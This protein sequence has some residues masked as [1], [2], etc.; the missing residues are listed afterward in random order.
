MMAVRERENLKPFVQR[1]G[2]VVRCANWHQKEIMHLFFSCNICGTARHACCSV[3][4]LFPLTWNESSCLK[5]SG[6]SET[7]ASLKN[8]TSTDGKKK[9]NSY[10]ILKTDATMKI[11]CLWHF[12]PLMGSNTTSNVNIG[13]AAYCNVC[14]ESLKTSVMCVLFLRLVSSLFQ[15]RLLFHLAGRSFQSFPAV[16]PRFGSD[17]SEHRQEYVCVSVVLSMCVTS[18]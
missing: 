9:T 1:K 11:P 13:G 2:P 6:P 12:S 18:F 10:S 16:P 15:Q 8:F 3:E 5:V 7:I 14:C 17:G 4:D